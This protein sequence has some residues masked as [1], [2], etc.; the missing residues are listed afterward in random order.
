[1]EKSLQKEAQKTKI[2]C[3]YEKELQNAGEVTSVAYKYSLHV[4][5]REIDQEK[6]YTCKTVAC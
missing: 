3:Y 4:N 1:M 5:N 2:F 6:Q